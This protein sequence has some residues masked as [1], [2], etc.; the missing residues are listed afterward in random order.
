MTW[1]THLDLEPQ[2]QQLSNYCAAACVQMVLSTMGLRGL[3][4]LQAQP[5]FYSST[6]AWNGPG[7]FG[8]PAGVAATINRY[9]V[10]ERYPRVPPVMEFS[11]HRTP[12]PYQACSTVVNG[13]VEY[14]AAS[15]VMV[16]GSTHWIVVYGAAGDGTPRDGSAF[17]IALLRMCNPD[18]GFFNGIPGG[19]TGGA[20][21]KGFIDEWITYADFLYTYFSGC[22]DNAQP[23]WGVPYA[24]GRQFVFVTDRRARA[25]GHLRLPRAQ[26]IALSVPPD[27]A[28]AVFAK[29]PFAADLENAEHEKPLCVRRADRDA[30]FYYL[31][32]F[33]LPH[34][35]VRLV[36]LDS[37]GNFLGS[38]SGH[39][40]WRAFADPARQIDFV[41]DWAG[42]RG[43]GL[44]PG[45]DHLHADETLVW[46]PSIESA[47]PY[48]VFRRVGNGALTVYVSW[49]G[50]VVPALHDRNTGRPLML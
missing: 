13:L 2:C 29:S 24:D 4:P 36:R 38:A 21:A 1:E 12:M 22:N 6:N 19:G 33:A 8:R 48:N 43:N 34:G 18:N 41:R 30:E 49:N 28:L 16:L 7:A 3:D 20:S 26:D 32:P 39:A 17:E 47:S 5:V 40:D 23:S 46:Q 27:E 9:N 35:V 37:Q 44:R 10:G 31:V 14:G 42:R 15:A 45:D 50:A 25:R 11:E